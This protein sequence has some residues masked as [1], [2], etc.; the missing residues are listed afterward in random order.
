MRDLTLR[1][2]AQSPAA[3]WLVC[4]GAGFLIEAVL[5]RLQPLR[6]IL[7]NLQV[8]LLYLVIIFMLTPAVT[9]LVNT[10]TAALGLGFFD[11]RWLTRAGW[12]WEIALAFFNLFVV[13]FFIYWFHRAQHQIPFLWDV[14]AAHHADEHLNVTTTTT[15]N[16]LHFIQLAVLVTLPVAI[17]FKLPELTSATMGAILG[18][19]MFFTHL[20]V[21]WSWGR[22]SW[23]FVGPQVHRIHHSKL[24]EHHDKNFAGYFPLWDVLFG[25]Y[26]APKRDEYP[27]TGLADGGKLDTVTSIT[28]G[29]IP[30][31][32]RSATQT[33][34]LLQRPR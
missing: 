6:G 27:P 25:T 5:G 23:V 30:K 33:A 13:D 32:A 22:L 7:V 14:H 2:W 8:T 16:W 9:V 3:L 31:W 18:G 4:L 20:N 15:H 28:L 10:G 1:F 21:Q 34:R 24:R 17:L 11:L 26:H 29:P 12:G 19:W